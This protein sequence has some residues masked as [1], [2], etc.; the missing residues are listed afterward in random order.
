DGSM[1]G[2]PSATSYLLSRLPGWQ[3]RLPV[4]VEYLEGM[5]A[6]P[7]TGLPAF[8]PCDVFARAWTI[9]YLQHGGLLDENKDLLLPHYE[10]LMM[11][12]RPDGVGFAA[13]SGFVD[14]DDTATTLLVLHRAGYEVDG[15]CLLNFEQDHCFAVYGYERNPSVSANLHV[16]EAL[17]AFP[18]E[19]RARVRDK[20]I[21][22]LLSARQQGTYWTDKWHASVY[23]PTTRALMIMSDYVPQEMKQTLEWLLANQRDDGSWGQYEST[24]EETSLTLLALLRY[25][26]TVRPLPREPLQRA[27]EYLLE[28]EKHPRGHPELWVCKTLYAPIF[29]IEACRLAAL[30]NYHHAFSDT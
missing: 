19:D 17:D 6:Q 26:A 24:M 9:Y 29:A 14:S 23:Y 16:L 7:R 27:A 10:H 11:N 18:E 3:E 20:I 2:S 22:Y 4:S 5:L 8:H 15:S 12:L 30:S 25:H 1:A 28:H 13:T 21:S